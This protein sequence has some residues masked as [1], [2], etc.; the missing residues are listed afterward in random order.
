MPDYII[1]CLLFWGMIACAV[2]AIESGVNWS[3]DLDWSN[4]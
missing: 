1:A 2:V 4:L 3:E